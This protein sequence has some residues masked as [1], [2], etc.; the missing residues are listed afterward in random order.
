MISPTV[1]T[2]NAQGTRGLA[3]GTKILSWD[4]NRAVFNTK[5]IKL[6]VYYTYVSK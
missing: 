4:V 6:K 2:T 5:N 3:S 1:F